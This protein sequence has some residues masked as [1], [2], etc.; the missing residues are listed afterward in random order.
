MA[1]GADDVW[2]GQGHDVI[3]GDNADIT[4]AAGSD[5]PAGFSQGYDCNTFRLSNAADVVIRRS[6][7]GTSTR[8]PPIRPPAPRTATRSAARTPTTG[9]T[10]R[11]AATPSRAASATTSR[12]ATQAP[13]RS[14]AATA[15]T[16][17]SAAPGRT[18]SATPSSAADGRIDANDVIQGEADF[19]AISGDNAR[20]VRQTQDGDAGNTRTTPASG[21][22]TRSTTRSIA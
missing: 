17:W 1:D 14:S 19:D 5:C 15:R 18:D 2:G 8:R 11:V 3:A 12:S 6:R 16:T 22:R 10:A 4:R 7:S 20:I 13:T 9:C 21:R